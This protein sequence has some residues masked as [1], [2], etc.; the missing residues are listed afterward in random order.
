MAKDLVTWKPNIDKTGATT[1]YQRKSGTYASGKPRKYRKRKIP[2]GNIHAKAASKFSGEQR[3]LGKTLPRMAWG[4]AKWAWRHPIASTALA[5]V[6]S[7]MKKITGRQ[8][9][10]EWAPYRQYNKKGRKIR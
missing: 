3:F 2:K 10:L 4:A 9:G 1:L 8:R 7:A 5:F 6:P